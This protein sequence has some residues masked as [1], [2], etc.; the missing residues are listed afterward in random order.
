M[1]AL[2]FL[3]LPFQKNK[4]FADAYFVFAL[5]GVTNLFLWTLV[6]IILEFFSVVMNERATSPSMLD[7]L[8]ALLQYSRATLLSPATCYRYL[9][10]QAHVLSPRS[11]GPSGKHV[12]GTLPPYAVITAALATGSLAHC[13]TI[14]PEVLAAALG[15]SL[16]AAG[17]LIA[18]VAATRPADAEAGWSPPLPADMEQALADIELAPVPEARGGAVQGVQR[19]KTVVFQRMAE[20][21]EA[22]QRAEGPGETGQEGAA[23]GQLL[24]K[25]KELSAKVDALSARRE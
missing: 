23:L 8:W 17:Y 10:V 24:Q 18:Q 5:Y 16:P 7:E 20:Q 2:S 6:G 11:F 22:L 19:S 15:V 9:T 25:I 4:D 1:P 21:A 14:T 3:L 12:D 13:H